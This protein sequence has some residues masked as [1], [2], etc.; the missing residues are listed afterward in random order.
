MEKLK[1]TGRDAWDIYESAPT[2][3]GRIRV[4]I[5]QL[6]PTHPSRYPLSSF[7]ERLKS[8]PML[9]SSRLVVSSKTVELG[10]AALVSNSVERL[11][12]HGSVDIPPKPPE[13]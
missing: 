4:L 12:L 11:A 5:L 8:S 2:S 7:Q 9:K 3:T 1:I 10:H 13:P 6:T